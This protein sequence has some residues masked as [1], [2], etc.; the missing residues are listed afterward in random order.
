MSFT[1]LH[2]R[3]K[4]P[5]F[6]YPWEGRTV[7]GTTDLDHPDPGNDEAGI[8]DQELTYLLELVDYQFPDTDLSKRLS[9]LFIDIVFH[10]S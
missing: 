3:D 6:V 2:P 5:I 4:R 9:Y 7:I 8:T 10:D 1:V